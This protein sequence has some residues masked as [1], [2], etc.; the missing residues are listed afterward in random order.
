MSADV[1]SPPEV[2][3]GLDI[4]GTKSQAAAFDRDLNQITE[5]RVPTIAGS[6]EAVARLML[7]TIANLESH[8]DNRT[9]VGI[10]VGIPG[11]VDG[12]AGSVRQAVNL[13]IG[14]DPLDVVAHLTSVYDV[15]CR[16]DNDVNVA[17]L[18]A[19]R[20]LHT[21]DEPGDLAYLSIGTGIAAGVVLN[22]RLYQGRRGVAGE[23]GHFPVVP[24]GPRCECGLQGCLEAVASGMAIGRQWPDPEGLSPAAS[25][26]AQANLGDERAAAVLEPIA[27]HLAKAVYLLAITYDPDRI[28]VGGGVADIGGPLLDVIAEGL[29][30]LETSSGF[31][32]SL[33]LPSR[34]LLKPAG[35][36][37]AIGAAALAYLD[38]QR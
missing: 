28:V 15:P 2:L 4:G 5:L 1:G 29:R 17:A 22:G 18:G 16:V 26:I 27:D 34:L 14:D 6:S 13:G 7:D 19:Y 24:D 36:V 30:R 32:R 10:G 33:E 21:D 9:I 20:I 37:G 11:L 35:P 38:H 3:V 23:I 31:V 8:F 12:P 25:L